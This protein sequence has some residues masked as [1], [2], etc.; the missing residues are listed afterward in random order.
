LSE[1]EIEKGSLMIMFG[2]GFFF[3]NKWILHALFMYVHTYIKK[4]L[5]FMFSTRFYFT[6]VPSAVSYVNPIFRDHSQLVEPSCSTAIEPVPGVVLLKAEYENG[7][8]RV[9]AVNAR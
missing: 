1:K 3:L 4:N 6:H 8:L 2:Y 5:I 9:I 7:P